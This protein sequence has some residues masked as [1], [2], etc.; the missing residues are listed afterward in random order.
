MQSRSGEDLIWQ[1]V[2]LRF[3]QGLPGFLG[4]SFFSDKFH[5]YKCLA[6]QSAFALEIICSFATWDHLSTAPSTLPP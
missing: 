5:P 2:S 3:C 4:L 1:P 6:Q